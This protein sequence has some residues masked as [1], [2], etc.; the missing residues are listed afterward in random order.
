M[1]LIF[2]T[3]RPAPTLR[4][5]P[6]L[7]TV[8]GWSTTGHDP[9][10]PVPVPG[11]PNPE[12]PSCRSCSSAASGPQRST[13]RCARS[14]VPPTAPSSATVDEAGP[15]DA[16]AAIA[17]ARDAFDSGPWPGTPAAERGDLLLRVADLLERDKDA[18][19]RAESL[20]TGKRLVESEYD[21]DDIANCFRYFGHLAAAGGPDRIVDTG[22]PERRQPGRARAGRRLR[23]DHPVE[24]SAAADRL[25]GRAG[26]RARATPSSSSRAS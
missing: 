14:A 2:P 6:D 16:A 19:A 25:E 20:D 4:T 13:G 26:A 8:N 11:H 18:L 22:N 21:I 9:A 7:L 23:A 3:G 15:K 1:L 12:E 17:A 5:R 24:L 10:G